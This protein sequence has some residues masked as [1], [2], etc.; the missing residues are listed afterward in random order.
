[1]LKS[2]CDADDGSLSQ[3][4]REKGWHRTGRQGIE[5]RLDT[6]DLCK[7]GNLAYFSRNTNVA[8]DTSRHT[9]NR[10]PKT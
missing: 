6:I 7:L 1:M 10:L 2:F 4:I 3:G 9:S 8:I 5:G